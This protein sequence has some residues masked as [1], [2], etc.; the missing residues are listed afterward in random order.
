MASSSSEE[1]RP[2]PTWAAYKCRSACA[3]VAKKKLRAAIAA[4]KPRVG[5]KIAK[6]A[7]AKPGLPIRP[8]AERAER[9]AQVIQRRYDSYVADSQARL[10]AIHDAHYTTVASLNAK[11]AVKERDLNQL[12]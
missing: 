10:A 8:P 6:G 1:E 9:E 11:L 5:G 3:G 2:I 12:R 7:S 4:E